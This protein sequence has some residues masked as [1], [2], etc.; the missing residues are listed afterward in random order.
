MTITEPTGIAITAPRGGQEDLL[1]A[2]S[3]RPASLLM[4]SS[5]RCFR[6]EP[7]TPATHTSGDST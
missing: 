1:Q 2:L 3:A 7:V 5:I 6:S 4:I